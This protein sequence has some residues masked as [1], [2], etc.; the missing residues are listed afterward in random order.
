MVI[1][2][3]A[4]RSGYTQDQVGIVG[5]FDDKQA[6]TFVTMPLR[7][8]PGNHPGIVGRMR[9]AAPGLLAIDDVVVSVP[10]RICPDGRQVRTG[11]GLA[12]PQPHLNFPVGNFGNPVFFVFFGAES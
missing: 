3:F 7:I 2:C 8:C 1:I 11:I 6:D 10:D 4:G 9:Q 12:L 5:V